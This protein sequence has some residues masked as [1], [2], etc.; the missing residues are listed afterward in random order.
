[1]TSLFGCIGWKLD[2]V[3]GAYFGSR[4]ALSI[5]GTC[6]EFGVL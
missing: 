2:E 1:M 4:P 6:K 5:P 3:G